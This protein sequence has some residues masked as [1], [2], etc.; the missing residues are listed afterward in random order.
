[1]SGWFSW[2]DLG[3]FENGLLTEGIAMAVELVLIVNVLG[4][5]RRRDEN[6]RFARYRTRIRRLLS[7]SLTEMSGMLTEASNSLSTYRERVDDLGQGGDAL[8]PP[9]ETARLICAVQRT[10]ERLNRD[11]ALYLANMDNPT[12]E[13]FEAWLDQIEWMLA[14]W[15]I[16][17]M[18]D[19]NF[20]QR[21]ISEDTLEEQ[22]RYVKNLGEIEGAL[23]ETALICRDIDGSLLYASTQ[24]GGDKELLD[25]ASKLR[26]GSHVLKGA[27]NWASQ[28]TRSTGNV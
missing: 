20:S 1:M 19:P 15:P 23:L 27:R 8:P 21:W 24:P 17:R 12:A 6:L 16:W 10:H 7:R 2:F 18:T 9:A 25:T 14:V 13:I 26:D 3:S 28:R 5:L 11:Y 4:W 22:R